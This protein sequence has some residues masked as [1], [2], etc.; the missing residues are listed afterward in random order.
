VAAAVAVAAGAWL[1]WQRMSPDTTRV[2]QAP[3]PATTSAPT[4]APPTPPAAPSKVAAPSAPTRGTV[5][6]SAVALVDP[7]DARYNGDR[8]KVQEEARADAK[9]QVVAKALGLL[10][11]PKSLAQHYGLLK[12]KL[13]SNSGA[14]IDM[15]VR[16]SEPRVGKDGLM[17]VTTDAVVN[18]RALQKSLNE[19]TR[20]ERVEI[21]RAS[22]APKVSVQVAVR[23]SDQ[24]YAPPVPS[25]VAENLLKER[26]KSFGFRTWSEG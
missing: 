25:P 19:M 11:D 6:I 22:A 12:T 18:V 14:Y 2:A 26:I 21:I 8:A 3:A 5:A 9:S 23:D 7:S 17:A 10:V 4:P 1:A 20:D 15:V 24:A 16:E 13:L